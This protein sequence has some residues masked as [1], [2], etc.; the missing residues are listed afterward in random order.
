MHTHFGMHPYVNFGAGS[1]WA[2]E[3]KSNTKN[4]YSRLHSLSTE[5]SEVK[6]S[7]G[8]QSSFSARPPIPEKH[9][10]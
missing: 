7:E 10:P 3:P 4:E 5:S 6:F 1:T 8:V 9:H 2:V